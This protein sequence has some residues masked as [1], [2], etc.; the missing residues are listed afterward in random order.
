[1]INANYANAY[2]EVLVILDKLIEEDYNKI[3]KNYIEF[4]EQNSNKEYNFKYDDSKD[5]EQQELLLDTKYIL[6][7]LFEKFGT[8]EL[9]KEKIKAFRNNYYNKVEQ[10][11]REQYNPDGIFK[12]REN[13]EKIS[14]TEINV[15]TDT[16]ALV[17]C[18]ESFFTR[19]LNKILQVFRIK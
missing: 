15:N 5:F 7:G 4:L 9:Q 16:I 12:K 3:P 6:F 14:G 1:M 17:E 2:K 18:K 11:K 8:T 19:I 13:N 10:E